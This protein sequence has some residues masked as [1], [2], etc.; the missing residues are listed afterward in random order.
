[1]I[2]KHSLWFG[3]LVVAWGAATVLPVTRLVYSPTAATFRDGDIVVQ[4]TFPLD[5]LGLPRPRISYEET[6]R[7]LTQEHNAGHVCTDA[8]GPFRYARADPVGVW[9]LTW[10]DGCLDDPVGFVWSAH[11]YWHIGIFQVGGV[12]LQ[13][14]ELR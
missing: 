6:V 14:T 8:A 7:P 4:R 12:S 10:A 11:W 2:R 1:M 5:V 9:G 3:W 13:H